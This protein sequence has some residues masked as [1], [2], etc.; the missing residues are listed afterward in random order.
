MKEVGFIFKSPTANIL[1]LLSH[2]LNTIAPGGATGDCTSDERRL[3][4]APFT[5]VSC[6]TASSTAALTHFLFSV[7]LIL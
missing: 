4:R 7:A 3:P 5:S 6:C 2:I 1:C